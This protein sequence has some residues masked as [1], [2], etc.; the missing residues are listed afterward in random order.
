VQAVNGTDRDC[1]GRY[2]SVTVNIDV[3]L[4]VERP[5]NGNTDVVMRAGDTTVVEFT[6]LT[7]NRF[8]RVVTV[9]AN[10]IGTSGEVIL[11]VDAQ[12]SNLFGTRVVSSGASE[13]I[14]IETDAE[15]A[16][17]LAAS[18]TVTPT[19]PAE[20]ET[21]TLQASTEGSQCDIQ[22]YQWD[23]DGDGEFESN[24]ASIGVS[25]PT[26][27]PKQVTLQVQDTAGITRETTKEILVFHDPD[28]DN[29]T[30]YYERQQGTDPFDPDTDGDLFNDESDPAPT[31]ALFPTGVVHLG[32]A[33]ILYLLGVVFRE[34]LQQAWDTVLD[35]FR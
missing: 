1:D 12:R 21:A 9:T 23:Y 14:L 26:D 8:S 28:G 25:Y 15:D 30:T 33:G 24:G 16:S 5:A 7:G 20:N 35:R 2:S 19:R 31:T 13:P 4:G 27:G 11:S 18:F 29:V 32:L 6:G 22:S 34:R 3:L 10:E 17:E